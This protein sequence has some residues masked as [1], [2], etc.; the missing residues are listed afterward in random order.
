MIDAA[1]VDR[2]GL[3]LIGK[4]AKLSR[5][6]ALAL[7]EQEQTVFSESETSAL[8]T[9]CKGTEAATKLTY[10]AQRRKIFAALWK[11]GASW[12]QL[13]LLYQIAK[14]TV[15]QSTRR[16][17]VVDK[18]SLAQKATYSRVAEYNALY[19][20]QVADLQHKTPREIALWLLAHTEVDE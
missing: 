19:W 2:A 12:G 15:I 3:P 9:L 13:A 4:I 17:L 8:L 5:F 6:E 20:S 14:P 18:I 10:Y 11:L 1:L 16:G 7:I